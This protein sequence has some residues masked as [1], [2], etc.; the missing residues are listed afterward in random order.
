MAGF[1]NKM[2]AT[3]G[4]NSKALV[5]KAKIKTAIGN[6]ESE[7]TELVRLLGQKT[8]DMYKANGAL[9][10]DENMVNI[11]NQI[12]KKKE[13]IEQQHE[14][15]KRVEEELALVNR[16][17]APVV[18]EGGVACACGHI[19]RADAK[20]CAG[21]GSTIT[22]TVTA[23]ESGTACACGH[24]NNADSK[25]CVGCGSPVKGDA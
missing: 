20:F 13:S 9:T 1:L 8:Y 7:R 17:S 22:V 5:D 24:V 11:I 21:C 14:Q 3:V 16:S 4:A 10:P 15:L 25:F 12:D 19:N 18:P 6:F 2:V 23:T